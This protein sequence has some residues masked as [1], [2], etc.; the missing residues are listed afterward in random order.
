V[1]LSTEFATGAV[2][3]LR[4]H[5]GFLPHLWIFPLRAAALVG[6]GAAVLQLPRDGAAWNPAFWAG[7]GLAV[8]MLLWTVLDFIVARRLIWG[9]EA[10]AAEQ[11]KGSVG[12]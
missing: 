1:I 11:A 10:P 12:R 9:E 5:E 3:N 8:L 4:C 2:D 7:L 6:G